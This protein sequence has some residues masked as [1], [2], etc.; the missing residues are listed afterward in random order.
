MHHQSPRFAELVDAMLEGQDVESFI[1]GYDWKQADQW[2]PDRSDWRV[3]KFLADHDCAKLAAVCKPCHVA[4][5]REG[6]NLLKV[7]G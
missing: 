2:V 6:S 5:H 3:A 7:N 1:V 4:E